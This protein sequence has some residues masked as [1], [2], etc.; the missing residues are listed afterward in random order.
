VQSALVGHL[1]A[2]GYT[3]RS[4]ADTAARSA[5]KDIVATG[6]DGRMLRVSVKGYQERSVHVQA[7]HWLAGALMD[8]ARYREESDDIELAIGLPDG[9]VTYPR[10]VQGLTKARRR[11]EFGIYWVAGNGTVSLEPDDA[12]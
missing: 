8:M 4:T 6:P 11:L 9:F 3:I 2:N 7:R 5:G 10:L 1:A 12:G